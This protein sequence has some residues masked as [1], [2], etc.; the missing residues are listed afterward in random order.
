MGMTTKLTMTDVMRNA[1]LA[2]GL[3]QKRLATEAGVSQAAL[4]LFL[5]GRRGLTLESAEKLGRV[6]GLEIRTVKA[7][8]QKRRR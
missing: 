4:S 3:S 7:V 2:S 6:L 8:D 1:I 5:S